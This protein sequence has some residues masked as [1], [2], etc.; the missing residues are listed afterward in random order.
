M[1]ARRAFL[2]ALAA[3]SAFALDPYTSAQQ[4]LDS[5]DRGTARPGSVVEFSP[6]EINA[7]VRAEIP[8]TVPEGIRLP[9]VE[10]GSGTAS[11]SAIVNFLKLRQAKSKDASPLMAW[12]LNGEHPLK[13]SVRLQSSNGRCTV[14]L[15]RLELSGAAISGSPLDF[16]IQNFFRP[17]YP[18]ARINEPFELAGNIDRIEITPAAIRVS[19]RR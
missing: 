11:G 5:L 13:V 14:Y 8:M 7:W 6:A 15:T 9:L 17:L 19:V 12:M 18:G 16:L 2:L 4:K 1:H 3:S 10:L